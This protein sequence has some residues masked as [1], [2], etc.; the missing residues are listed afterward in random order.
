M[1]TGAAIVLIA[2]VACAD[3][4]FPTTAEAMC[5]AFTVGCHQECAA[6]PMPA[7]DG[8]RNAL[9]YHI[10]PVSCPAR[11]VDD[12]QR[13]A[14]QTCQARGMSLAPGEALLARRPPVGALPAALTA[15]FH[16]QV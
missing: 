11:Y 2:L 8:D 4:G 5:G 16:C 1:V 10:G 6:T 15:T 3:Y 9:S 13:A 14:R 7:T 12:A